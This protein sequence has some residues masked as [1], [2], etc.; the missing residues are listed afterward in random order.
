[1]KARTYASALARLSATTSP[2]DATKGLVAALTAKGR[3]K[4]L[5]VILREMKRMEAGKLATA[6]LVEVARAGDAKKALAAAEAEG[7][8]AKEAVVNESLL[9]GWR[10]RGNGTLVDRSGKKNLLD[11]YR[12]ITS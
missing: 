1:M 8:T 12:K 7:V 3:I 9:S 5:P 11:L 2:A 10:A 4:L 6:P